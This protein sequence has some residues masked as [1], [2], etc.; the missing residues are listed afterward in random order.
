MA[1]SMRESLKGI[2]LTGSFSYRNDLKGPRPSS[3]HALARACTD[4]RLS[5]WSLTPTWKVDS[6]A[7]FTEEAQGIAGSSTDWFIATNADDDSEGLYRLPKGATGWSRKRFSAVDEDDVHLG[8]PCVSKG[9]VYVPLQ[10]SKRGVWKVSTD[11]TKQI[12]LW[13]AEPLDDDD[14]FPWCDIN[15]FNGLLYTCNFDNPKGLLAYDAS[16]TTSG[17]LIRRKEDDL[18]LKENGVPIDG[19]QGACFTPNYR[20]LL[21][22]DVRDKDNDELVLCHSTL[23]GFRQGRRSVLANTDESPAPNTWNELEGITMQSILINGVK[24]HVQVLELNNEVH[25][26]DDVYLWGLVVSQ[27]ALL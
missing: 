2:G 13:A 17:V 15:P 11:F 26:S 21:I 12:T 22:R 3:L 1:V 14:L 6:G 16:A 8:A 7:D 10:A 4:P 24:T 25:S 18:P 27:P 23:T 9:W 19:V 5:D 20:V